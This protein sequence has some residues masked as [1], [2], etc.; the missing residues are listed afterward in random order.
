M[1]GEAGP[2]EQLLAVEIDRKPELRRVV[3]PLTLA[4]RDDG[5]DFRVVVEPDINAVP[6]EPGPYATPVAP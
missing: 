3:D 2:A 1:Q 6:L 5:G 4:A